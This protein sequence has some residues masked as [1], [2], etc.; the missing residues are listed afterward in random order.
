MDIEAPGKDQVK[1]LVEKPADGTLC[2]R[3]RPVAPIKPIKGTGL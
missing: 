2:N 1:E 3:A